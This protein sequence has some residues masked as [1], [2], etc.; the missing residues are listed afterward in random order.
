MTDIKPKDVKLIYVGD[1][2]CSW[3]YGFS[4]ELTQ[5]VEY[6]SSLELEMVMGGLRPYNTQSMS[7]LKDFLSHHWKDVQDASGQE[8]SYGILDRTDITYDTEPP[9]RAS[10][11][12]RSLAPEK[13]LAFF[14]S[15]QRSFYKENKNLH[16][17]ES[18]HDLLSN[19]DIDIQAFDSAFNSDDMK[20]A[21]KNDFARARSIGV[22]SFPTLLIEKEGK[23]YIVAQGFRKSQ[24]IIKD[25]D[26][27]ISK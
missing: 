24:D 22:N 13:E 7:D 15:V 3:C 26:E 5:V 8:F 10:L 4:D 6:Y 27:I 20:T 23:K 9:C 18:Y 25:I 17:V 12:V 14:K 1:P 11:V 21:I 16:L 19:L 2:M